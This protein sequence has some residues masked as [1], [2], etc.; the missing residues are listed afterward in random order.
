MKPQMWA[1]LSIQGSTPKAKRKSTTHSSLVKAL[2]GWARICQLWNSSTN[3]QARIPNCE[4]AGPTWDKDTIERDTGLRKHNELFSLLYLIK[5][6]CHF[7]K[8]V[9]S[10]WWSPLLCRAGKWLKLSWQWCHWVCK[11]LKCATSLPASPDP[12]GW[13]SGKP[14]TPGSEGFWE[15]RQWQIVHMCDECDVRVNVGEKP[16]VLGR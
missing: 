3:R 5:I 6:T 7:V 1:K 16:H 4:P 14:P 10:S 12:S 11:W 8:G 13:S 9:V 2:Q 15:D